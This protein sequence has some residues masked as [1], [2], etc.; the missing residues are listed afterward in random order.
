MQTSAFD[1][2]EKPASYSLLFYSSLK[3]VF[4]VII[5]ISFI[6]VMHKIKPG[7]YYN[8]SLSNKDLEKKNNI[9]SF[10]LE[11]ETNVL[12]MN[13]N[14][15]SHTLKNKKI[16]LAHTNRSAEPHSSDRILSKHT[17]A[18]PIVVAKY[19]LVYFPN[20]KVASTEFKRLLQRMM[21]INHTSKQGKVHNPA[22]N[23]LVYLLKYNLS[24]VKEIMTSKEWTRFIFLRNPKDRFLSSFLDKAGR[25]SKFF[26]RR[27]CWDEKDEEECVNQTSNI[28]YFFR[29]TK[30]C[31]DQ[32]WDPQITLVDLKWWPYINFIGDF[33]NLEE[34]TKLLLCSLGNNVWRKYGSNGWGENCSLPI[35]VRN[36]PKHKTDA[37]SQIK[38]YYTP[39]LERMVEKRFQQDYLMLE[40]IGFRTLE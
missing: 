6:L 4:I 31:H 12:L 18:V 11:K 10:N 7:Y 27:C 35:F 15:C 16:L 33:N 30:F 17:W 9:L 3:R 34:D 28:S 25:Q 2:K 13:D 21:G 29:R 5:I 22:T 8:Y 39:K 38:K 32:H 1:A 37:S 40:Q 20:P 36:D 26:K 14:R 24:E 19:K 23:G